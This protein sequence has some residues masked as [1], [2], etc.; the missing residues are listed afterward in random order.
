M[1]VASQTPILQDITDHLEPVNIT[2]LCWVDTDVE[3]DV[4]AFV[5]AVCEVQF[6]DAWRC[7]EMYL[8]SC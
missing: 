6:K 1:A 4:K 8:F 5:S 7:L 3:Y 2:L